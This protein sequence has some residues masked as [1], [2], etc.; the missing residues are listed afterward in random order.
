M[1]PYDG[2]GWR[3]VSRVRNAEELHRAYN[4]SVEM[5]MHLQAAAARSGPRGSSGCQPHDHV[6]VIDIPA[7]FAAAIREAL[8]AE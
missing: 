2:G 4:E 1:K 5:L 7:Q 3:G 6:R 8:G